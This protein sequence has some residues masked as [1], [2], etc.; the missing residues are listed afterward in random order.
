MNDNQHAPDGRRIFV[1]TGRDRAADLAELCDAIRD[2]IPELCNRD[3]IARLDAGGGLGPINLA[4]FRSLLDERIC[5][6]RVVPNGDGTWG[7]EYFSFKFEPLPRVHWDGRGPYP[8]EV[9]A[10]E[11]DFSVLDEVYRTAL[12]PLLPRVKE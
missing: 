6:V 10:T 4:G 3:G 12:V 8:P 9:K 7:R 11:P 1:W 5:G 2:A